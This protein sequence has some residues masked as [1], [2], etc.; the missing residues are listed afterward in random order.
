M[1]YEMFALIRDVG[2]REPWGAAVVL[3]DMSGYVVTKKNGWKLSRNAAG[4]ILGYD[5]SDLPVYVTLED[6]KAWFVKNGIAPSPGKV[7]S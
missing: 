6:L 4:Y 5:S 7:G 1:S 2:S 3:S